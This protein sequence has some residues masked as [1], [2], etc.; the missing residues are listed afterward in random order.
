M[1]CHVSTEDDCVVYAK[2]ALKGNDAKRAISNAMDANLDMGDFIKEKMI[3]KPQQRS[4]LSSV[5]QRG[6]PVVPL[7]SQEPVR[8]W[9]SAPPT[10]QF[11]KYRRTPWAVH[12]SNFL[13]ITLAYWWGVYTTHTIN[14]GTDT[15]V[16]FSVILSFA[17]FATAGYVI[18]WTRKN[19]F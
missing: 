2:I 4:F 18:D 3:E 10:D 8:K 19:G 9:F 15:Q 7:A 12:I 11:P 16:F 17:I 6:T 14:E 1:W 13:L 5:P